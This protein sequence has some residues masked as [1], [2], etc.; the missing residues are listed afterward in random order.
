MRAC[1]HLCC[2]LI[3]VG[4]KQKKCAVAHLMLHFISSD[5]LVCKVSCLKGSFHGWSSRPLWNRH[6]YPSFYPTTQI[7]LAFCF[8][9]R[10]CLFSSFVLISYKENIWEKNLLKIKS[11]L[12]FRVKH[13]L[14]Q[15]Y[16]S[17]PVFGDQPSTVMKLL[18][19]SEFGY[20]VRGWNEIQI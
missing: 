13:H 18:Q 1:G 3:E 16:G 11:N 15:H 17:I 6:L 14:T 5:A 7:L 2:I 19:Y 8:S 12:I 4:C 10:S 9:A 20:S